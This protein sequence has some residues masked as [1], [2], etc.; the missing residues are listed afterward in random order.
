M[1]LKNPLFKK[2]IILKLDGSDTNIEFDW[3]HND[4]KNS[5]TEKNN[6]KQFYSGK[7]K[8]N[9]SKKLKNVN[10]ICVSI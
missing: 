1:V 9:G 5:L 6:K 3:L 8:F 10:L 7:T 4:K 2:K